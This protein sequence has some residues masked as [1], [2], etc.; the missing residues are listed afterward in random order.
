MFSLFRLQTIDRY[1]LLALLLLAFRLGLFFSTLPVVVPE[2]NWWLDGES[3]LGGGLLYQD[4]WDD[5]PPIPALI[6]TFL[7][8]L[9]PRSQLVSLIIGTL[10]TFFQAI[11][12]NRIL[13]R[14]GIVEE[15]SLMP[16]ATWVLFSHLN[17]DFLFLN[18]V[19]LGTTFLLVVLRNIFI[20]IRFGLEESKVYETGFWVGIAS[21]CYLPFALFVFL[22][23]ISFLLYT[24]TRPR[25]YAVLGIG[26]VFPFLFAGFF[27]QF[28]GNL[29]GFVNQFLLSSFS[30]Q[31]LGYVTPTYLISV[32]A[33]PF[34]FLVWAAMRVFAHRGYINY[35]LVCNV[36]MLFFGVVGLSTYLFATWHQPASFYILLPL[37]SYFGAQWAYLV[38]KA[39][40][41]ELIFLGLTGFLII[42][43]YLP[44]LPLPYLSAQLNGQGIFYREPRFPLVVNKKVLVMGSQSTL[45]L[46][47]R[48]AT[49]YLNR[50]LAS[51]LL[52]DTLS[53]QANYE[54]YSTF[55]ADMP[56]VIYDQ[57][58]SLRKLFNRLPLLATYYEAAPDQPR[59]WFKKQASD[60][61]VGI[62]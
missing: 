34:A 52:D 21:L 13:T 37:F 23:A 35:Q 50:R 15:K 46:R 12:F 61:E 53:Y 45:Y 25:W 40:L 51:Y 8:Y 41:R 19:L 24:A 42:S 33:I 59:T 17:Y 9:A 18:P 55:R 3:M 38:R 26:F 48:L 28:M 57:D 43:T 27:F 5:I 1:L 29:D 44:F 7:A 6:Y 36:V 56:D 54:L 2:I 32:F 10:L 58:G 30:L 16:A 47:N 49:P 39:V 4:I 60:A 20:H 14:N 31:K 22:P 62:K 11:F